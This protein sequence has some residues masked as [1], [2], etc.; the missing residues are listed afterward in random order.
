MFSFAEKRG[1]RA[2]MQL[3]FGMIF[4]I[5]LIAIFIA[6]AV[7]GIKTF[8]ASQQTIQLNQFVSALQK[9]VNEAYGS[10]LSNRT[11]SYTIPKSIEQVCFESSGSNNLFLI[12]ESSYFQKTIKNIDIAKIVEQQKDNKLCIDVKSGKIS[13][14]IEKRFGESLVIIRKNEN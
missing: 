8:L 10:T 13:L 3:S 9:D 5:I 2:Q 14:V 7:Y 12:G 4:T 1:Q 11:E 6:F